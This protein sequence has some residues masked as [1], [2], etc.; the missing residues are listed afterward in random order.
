MSSPEEL[1]AQTLELLLEVRAVLVE[2]FGPSLD[3]QT[4][5]P[6][7]SSFYLARIR[8]RFLGHMPQREV[9]V[10]PSCVDL[11]TRLVNIYHLTLNGGDPATTLAAVRA[12]SGPGAPAPAPARSSNA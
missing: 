12:A 2:A 11:R 7:A 4:R 10:C 1:A 3:G 5:G 9:H 8:D 6:G